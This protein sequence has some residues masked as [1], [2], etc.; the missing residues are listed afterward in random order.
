MEEKMTQIF[1]GPKYEKFEKKTFSIPAFFFGGIY[2][3]Y[4]KMILHALAISFFTSILDTLASKFL[5]FGLMIIA[6]LCVRISIGLYFPIWY[7]KFYRNSTRKVLSET[8]GKSEEETIRGIQKKGGTS[9]AF[10]ILFIILNAV[11]SSTFN[12]IIDIDK[13]VANSAEKQI[14]E[15]ANINGHASFGDS[16]TIYVDGEQY[17]CVAKNPEAL[18]SVGDYDEISVT[19]Y[20]TEVGEEKTIVDY[21]LYN[22]TTN[23][24]LE[25]ITDEESLRSALGYHSIG[26]HEETLTLIEIDDFPGAGSDG[27]VSYTYY[28]YVFETEKGNSIEFRYKIYDDTVDKT[29]LLVEGEK[30][31]VKFDVEEDLFGYEYLITD[32]EKL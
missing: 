18:Y 20:Y 28:D 25:N 6:M 22:K 4:R 24:K 23:E 26:S 17:I 7:R 19:L 32:I 8:A 14:L 31:K 3:A 1:V 27:E 15:N 21:E 10:I 11:V 5:N 16:V 29:D 30:Y 13:V 9:I 12:K 2:F